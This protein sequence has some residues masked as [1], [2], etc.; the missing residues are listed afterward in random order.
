MHAIEVTGLTKHFGAFRAVHN[1]SFTVEGGRV[2]GFLGQNG[3][4]KSTTMRMLTTLIRPD[5]GSIRFFGKP[6]PGHRA[7][8]LGRIGAI[9]EKPDFYP[10]LSAFENLRIAARLSG[11]KDKRRL[12][13]VL[14]LTGIADRAGSKVRTYSQGM[15][16]RLGLACALV[17]NPDLLL[18]DEPTNGLDPQGI[19]DIRRLLLRLSREEGKTVFVSSHL[20]SEVEVM[21]DSMLIIDKG[22]KV[23]EGRV[24]DLL[25][26]EDTL[27]EIEAADGASALKVLQESPWA[28]R[29][30][31]GPSLVL[32]TGRESVPALLSYLLER[33][34]AVE[35]V[36]PRHSLEN[37]FLQLTNRE[38]NVVPHK[39]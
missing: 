32:R 24:R 39:N 1:L 2:Y 13:E 30:Q 8:L 28:A 21:A 6:L 31:E 38:R 18:L 34:V 35:G 37:Y 16:Q 22:E 4:G 15:K 12:G 23:I 25:N 11:V 7:E 36:Q 5:A 19:A 29:L 17:H 3:A 10:Y 27:V 33:G 9:V 26:P 20:L 14:E